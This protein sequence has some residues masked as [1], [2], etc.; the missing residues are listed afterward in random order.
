MKIVPLFRVTAGGG[1]AVRRRV[2]FDGAREQEGMMSG[3]AGGMG[4]KWRRYEN[5]QETEGKG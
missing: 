3:A 5:S 2:V 4:R 1:R